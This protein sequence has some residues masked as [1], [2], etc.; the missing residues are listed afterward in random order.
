MGDLVMIIFSCRVGLEIYTRNWIDSNGKTTY[1]RK[2]FFRKGK[3]DK[4]KILIS[5]YHD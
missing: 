3:Y 1:I 4:E 2:E 5:F